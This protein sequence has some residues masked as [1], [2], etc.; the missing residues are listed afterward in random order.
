MK[1]QVSSFLQYIINFFSNSLLARNL[2]KVFSADMLSKV[3]SVGAT[4]LVIRGMS[5]NDYA[6]YTVFYGILVLLPELVGC[7][8]NYS[9]VRFSTES[10]SKT[11]KRPIE[12]YI[13]SFLFQITLYGLIGLF[14]LLSS[15]TVTGI[16]FGGQSFMQALKYGL[17]GGIGFLITQAARGILQAEEKFDFYIKTLWG[18]QVIT[19]VVFLVL[20]IARQFSFD[21]IAKAVIF[22]E[23]FIGCVLLFLIF[24]D[25]ELGQ[26]VSVVRKPQNLNEIFSETSWLMAY[27][28]VLACFQRLDIFMLA[29]LST[30][31]E[32]ANYGV[33]FKYYTLALLPLTSVHTVLL[34]TFSKAHMQDFTVQKRF[35]WKWLKITAWII[36]L[37]IV[38]DIFSRPLF[39]W[40][41]GVAYEKSFPILVVFSC[42]IWLSLMFSPLVNI[43]VSRKLFKYLF[44]LGVSS[45]VLNFIGNY[46]FIPKWGGM[47][48]ATVTVLS[49]GVINL[50]A[51]A[52]ILFSKDEE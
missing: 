22:V 21:Q 34:P 31:E 23:L 6:R 41:N 19:F 28:L 36:I 44:F 18:R 29:H 35:A 2:S 16:L 49:H 25:F 48:A 46:F 17:I 27:F 45:L 8:V 15:K 5:K 33:A 1:K 13:Y 26:I 47:A 10:I 51:G 11:N 24:R 40:I 52:K 14:L 7:G 30:T 20:F 39:V 38:F 4:L 37:I 9:L 42:G 32:L 12:L 43:I 3:F 50:I